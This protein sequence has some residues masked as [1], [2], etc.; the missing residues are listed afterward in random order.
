MNTY[1]DYLFSTAYMETAVSKLLE[2]QAKKI[3]L[4][5]KKGI[6]AEEINQLNKTLKEQLKKLEYLQML[7]YHKTTLLLNSLEVLDETEASDDTYQYKVI[8]RKKTYDYILNCKGQS[9]V[10]NPHDPYRGGYSVLDSYAH[11]PK[12]AKGSFLSYNVV[13]GRKMLDFFS[14]HSNMDVE[15]SFGAGQTCIRI[16]GTGTAMIR[17][18][19]KHDCFT[20]CGYIL[21]ITAPNTSCT[22]AAC[23]MNIFSLDTGVILHDSGLFGITASLQA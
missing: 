12:P 3:S 20:T 13:K 8:Q 9:A 23:K 6:P 16:K 19:E 2:T 10:T 11:I 4:L 1:Y 21:D 18:N 5:N 15:A 7:L 17:E 22:E 14:Q